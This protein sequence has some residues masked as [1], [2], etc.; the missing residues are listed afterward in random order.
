ME[1]VLLTES[2]LSGLSK[3]LNTLQGKKI[4]AD[5]KTTRSTSQKPE[6]FLFSTVALL[7]KTN[8][9][10]S[11]TFLIVHEEMSDFCNLSHHFLKFNIFTC[12]YDSFLHYISKTG[13]FPL[14]IPR[15]AVMCCLCPFDA[16]WQEWMQHYRKLVLIRLLRSMTSLMW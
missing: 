5:G 9:N 8:P 3:V 13:F 4:L 11:K 16:V 6:T 1:E 14:H 7:F 15:S 2:F 10:S 12:I